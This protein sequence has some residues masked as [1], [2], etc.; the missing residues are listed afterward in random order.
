[1]SVNVRISWLDDDELL[2]ISK[3]GV[4]KASIMAE[5]CDATCPS[6]FYRGYA[7]I[8]GQIGDLFRTISSRTALSQLIDE[9]D[10]TVKSLPAD[11]RQNGA[12]F[13]LMNLASYAQAGTV[14]EVSTTVA[15]EIVC[16]AHCFFRNQAR[17]L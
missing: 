3:R 15:A 4:P 17:G 13:A 16:I 1:M 7:T 2:S 8:L 12:S 5:R 11:E 9:F 14:P 6:E 10:L